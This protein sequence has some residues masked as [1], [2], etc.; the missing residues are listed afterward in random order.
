MKLY[1]KIS[2]HIHKCPTYTTFNEPPQFKT[3]NSKLIQTWSRVKSGVNDW[4]CPLL[5]H[6][7]TTRKKDTTVV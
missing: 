7:H 6:G 4:S 2:N 5:E 3:S 1:A